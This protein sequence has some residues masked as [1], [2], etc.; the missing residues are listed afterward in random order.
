[1]SADEYSEMCPGLIQSAGGL[2]PGRGFIF[3]HGSNP[4][5]KVKT[6]LKDSEAEKAGL[7]R[8]N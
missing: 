7:E 6:S 3:Q 2:Q 4:K 8:G 1:M 5:Q